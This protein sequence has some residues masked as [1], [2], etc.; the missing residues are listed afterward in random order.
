MAYNHIPVLADECL[1]YLN[2]KP[3]GVYADLTLGGGGHAARIAERI[4]ADGVLICIDRDPSVFENAALKLAPYDCEKHLVCANYSEVRHVLNERGVRGVCGALLDLGASSFQFDDP[5]RGFS[6]MRDGPLDMRM[7]Q[8]GGG[9]TARDIVNF[10][11]ERRLTHVFFTCGE[12]PR[13]KRI[14]GAI[15]AYRKKKPIE[16]TGELSAIVKR[17]V[18]Q[19]AKNGSH[20]AKRVFLALRIAVNDEL[21]H[22]K[23]ALDEAFAALRPGGRLVVISFQSLEDRAVKNAFLLYAKGCE[24]PRELPAC[25]CGKAPAGKMIVKKPITPSARETGV[26]PKAKSAK[27]RVF[28]KF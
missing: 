13:A 1:F 7:N 4:G 28:E 23:K 17:A 11:D 20:P 18:G 16:T 5:S 22:L 6:Y 12:E 10:Y 14:S 8:T 19:M 21:S 26:N 2:P 25:V 27:L 9:Q 24:C 15:C 3:G